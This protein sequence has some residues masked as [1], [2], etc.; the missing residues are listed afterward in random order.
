MKER[1]AADWEELARRE[2]YFAILTSEGLPDVGSGRV[3][4]PAYFETGESDVSSL[5][6]AI[7]LLL[8]REVPLTT[9][10]DFGC[11]AG[12]LTLPLARRATTVVACDIAPTMLAHARTNAAEAGLHNV[13]FIDSGALASL[14][15]GAFDFVCSL[16]VLQHIPPRVGHPLI[17]TLLSLLAPGGIAALQVTFERRGEGL[18]RLARATGGTSRHH[19]ANARVERPVLHTSANGYDRAVILRDVA[20][21]N[22]KVVGRF[23]THDQDTTGS[24]VIIERKSGLRLAFSVGCTPRVAARSNFTRAP[25]SDVSREDARSILILRTLE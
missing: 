17:R 5:L 3:A 10:L 8:G 18:R 25:E 9:A 23:E 4:T 19:R 16:L 2:P 24:V 14:A 15:P 7:A 1:G 22:A 12:R 6:A 11:G 21:A 20:A 13:T